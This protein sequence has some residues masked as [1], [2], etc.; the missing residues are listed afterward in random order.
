MNPGV[1]DTGVLLGLTDGLGD[2][3]A[4]LRVFDPEVADGFVGIGKA[5]VAALG[6]R[7]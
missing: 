6:V 1:H 7:E 2:G 4:A 5:E 3:A